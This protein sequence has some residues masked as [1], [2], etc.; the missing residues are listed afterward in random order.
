MRVSGHSVLY[1][2]AAQPGAAVGAGC[3]A[4]AAAEFAVHVALVD[5]AAGGGDLC[6]REAVRKE[7]AAEKG[8]PLHVVS[9]RRQA[10]VALEGADQLEAAQTGLAGE[11]MKVR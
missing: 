7:A 1:R 4:E 6:G 2:I 11:K 3:E 8:S 5:I 9:M 10:G